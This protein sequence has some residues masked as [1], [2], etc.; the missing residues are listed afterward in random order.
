MGLNQ[1]SMAGA[2]SMRLMS[3]KYPNFYKLRPGEEIE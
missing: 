3:I 2:L 1:A